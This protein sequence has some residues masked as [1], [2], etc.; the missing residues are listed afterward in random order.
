MKVQVVPVVLL[1][2]PRL[3]LLFPAAKA[4]ELL[5]SW[6]WIRVAALVPLLL[7][8]VTMTSASITVAPG[9]TGTFWKRAPIRVLS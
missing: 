8:G 4:G 2:L 9:R 7:L 5:L 1:R 6:K 3:L